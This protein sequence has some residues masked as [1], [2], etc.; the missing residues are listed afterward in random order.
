MFDPDAITKE[1]FSEKRRELNRRIRELSDR[2][3]EL[4]ESGGPSAADLSFIKKASA[5]LVA[6]KISS[7]E[8]IDFIQL[9]ADL[10]AEILKDFIDQIIDKI[11][12]QDGRI[13]RIRFTSGLEHEFIYQ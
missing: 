5:F 6:R 7:T 3:A 9:Y 2:A 8:Y 10:D 12:I 4:K 11:H 1:E 13:V